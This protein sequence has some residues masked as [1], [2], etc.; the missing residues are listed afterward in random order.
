MT[1]SDDPVIVGK[2]VEEIEAES[3]NRTSMR[4]EE[5][6]PLGIPGRSS[7]LGPVGGGMGSPAASDMGAFVENPEADSETSPGPVSPGSTSPVP[8]ARRDRGSEGENEA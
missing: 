4:E 8:G 3:G 6:G 7:G 1:Q 5:R 2:S